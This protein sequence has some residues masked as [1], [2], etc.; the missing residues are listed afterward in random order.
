MTAQKEEEIRR[1]FLV[2]LLESV[3]RNAIEGIKAQEVLII[4][5]PDKW[6]RLHAPCT[7]ADVSVAVGIDIESDYFLDPLYVG[8]VSDYV[9][10]LGGRTESARYSPA[11]FELIQHS[12][13]QIGYTKIASPNPSAP[14]ALG[15]YCWKY[16]KPPT[17]ETVESY[18]YR[19][20]RAEMG[21]LIRSLTE[22]GW[23]R[24][25]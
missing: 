2:G 10:A 11:L 8:L 19:H 20:I 23:G 6:I 15:W 4:E 3:R 13:E 25:E 24:V 22:L 7:L 1:R 5:H 17:P 9:G 12:Q 16:V 14:D 21:A 18:D